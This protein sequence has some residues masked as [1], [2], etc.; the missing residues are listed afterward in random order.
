MVYNVMEITRSAGCQS[1]EGCDFRSI[2]MLRHGPAD[3]F[4]LCLKKRDAG[5]ASRAPNSISMLC[6]EGW[7]SLTFN[8]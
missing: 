4:S 8:V 6:Y 5:L 7:R 3:L 2:C 1:C